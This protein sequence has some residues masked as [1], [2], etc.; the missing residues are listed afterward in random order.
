MDL[1]TASAELESSKHLITPRSLPL[2]GREWVFGSTCKQEHADHHFVRSWARWW[3]EPPLLIIQKQRRNYGTRPH[4]I[5]DT[6]R[7]P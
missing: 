7:H 5:I 4:K 2:V 6:R 3:S 1:R